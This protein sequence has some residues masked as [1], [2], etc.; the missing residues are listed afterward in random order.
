MHNGFF[1]VI[2]SKYKVFVDKRQ[3]THVL[4]RCAPIYVRCEQEVSFLEKKC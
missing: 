2:L 4:I 1:L 3:N